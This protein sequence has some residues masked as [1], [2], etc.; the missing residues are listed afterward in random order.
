[1]EWNLHWSSRLVLNLLHSNEPDFVSDHLGLHVILRHIQAQLVLLTEEL[2]LTQHHYGLWDKGHHVTLFNCGLTTVKLSLELLNNSGLSS[3]ATT[4]CIAMLKKL[5]KFFLFEGKTTSFLTD[6][7]HTC[8][9]CNTTT[10]VKWN[11]LHLLYSE[12]L[13][14]TQALVNN[15]IS[16]LT[17]VVLKLLLILTLFP[18]LIVTHVHSQLI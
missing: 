5:N 1:M 14:L 18:N 10:S 7:S 9:I 12:S 6:G 16:L 8:I 13:N 3:F 15:D 4:F 2:R 17:Y 11:F